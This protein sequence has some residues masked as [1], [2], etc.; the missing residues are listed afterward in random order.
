MRPGAALTGFLDDFSRA[1]LIALIKILPGNRVIDDVRNSRPGTG[2]PVLQPL[3]GVGRVY[4]DGPFPRDVQR[5][6]HALEPVKLV[7]PVVGHQPGSVIDVRQVESIEI[8]SAAFGNPHVGRW[9]LRAAPLR[10]K[11]DR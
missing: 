10:F 11:L 5:R 6:M 3:S 9:R 8:A 2:K 4:G 1:L 7:R